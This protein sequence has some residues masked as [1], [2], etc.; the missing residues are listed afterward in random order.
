MRKELVTNPSGIDP[1]L[2]A[3][4]PPGAGGRLPP[5]DCDKPDAAISP[6][7]RKPVSRRSGSALPG[8]RAGSRTEELDELPAFSAAFDFRRGRCAL[9][10]V[11]FSWDIA[12]MATYVIS[13]V[14]MT[15][16]GIG[17]FS[18]FHG[19]TQIGG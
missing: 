10:P 12:V 3:R 1:V 2:P 11:Q 15:F 13:S 18:L 6:G 9:D 4:M 7:D 14:G 16:P 5:V 19:A 17:T 8:R